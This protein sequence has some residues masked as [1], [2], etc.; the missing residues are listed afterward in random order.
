MASPGVLIHLDKG[1][2]EPSYSFPRERTRQRKMSKVLD[3]PSTM[4]ASGS[5]AS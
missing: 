3:R 1:S 4:L 2:K 5:A